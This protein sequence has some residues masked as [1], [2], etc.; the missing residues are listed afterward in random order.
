MAGRPF[1]VR[2]STG[3]RQPKQPI[4]G[5]DIAGTVEAVGS[6]VTRFKVG[7]QVL[8]W[9]S[10]AFAE[11]ASTP[12]DHLAAKP[13]RLSFEQAAA[14]GVS[15]TAALQL[16]RDNGKVKAGQKVL[17][18]G[19]SG[20]VGTFAVQIAKAFG[21]EVTGVTSGRNADLIRS[22]GADR[23]VDYTSE[24]FTK[25]AERY[26]FI[27]DNVANHT[28]GDMRR[29]LTPTGLLQ[30]NGGGHTGGGLGSVI[31]GTIM[32]LFVRGQGR[33]S[34]KFQNAA[35]QA[36]LVELIEAGNVTPAIDRTFSLAE[37][38]AALR[39]VGTGRAR[40]TVVITVAA[41]PLG[42]TTQTAADGAAAQLIAAGA[43]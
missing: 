7:E 16:L 32:S 14:V 10:G 11:F 5:T 30:P 8:G 9:T 26:D 42:A 27:L 17:I 2:I 33:P 34:V 21:A 41:P 3:L 6:G 15:A 1:L 37:T 24:D 29:M 22:I 18:N 23:V 36:A 31:R 40:G 35:D 20:G 25:G 13:A 28:S 12:E 38:A 19:A 43:A 39:Y 4:P